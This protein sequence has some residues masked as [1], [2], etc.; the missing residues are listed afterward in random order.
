[1]RGYSPH[2]WA[3]SYH[4]FEQRGPIFYYWHD[5]LVTCAWWWLL[6]GG[7]I[8]SRHHPSFTAY[9]RGYLARMLSQAYLSLVKWAEMIR[10][11][12]SWSTQNESCLS[13]FSY[14]WLFFGSVWIS[15]IAENWKHCNKIIFKCVNSTVGSSFKVKF[16]FFRT[17][18]SREQCMG[19]SQKNSNAQNATP[20]IIQTH[21]QCNPNSIA[22]LD[23]YL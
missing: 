15:L 13:E 18:G 2:Q 14:L 19:P 22:H 17:Y 6:F 3:P 11:C 1:M 21:T 20:A 23:E 5:L 4:I 9:L 10:A 7:W 8:P 16:M 12:S